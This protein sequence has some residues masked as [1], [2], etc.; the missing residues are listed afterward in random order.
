MHISSAPKPL[1]SA[2]PLLITPKRITLK[3]ACGVPIVALWLAN[4]TGI[5]EDMG[6]IPGLTQWVKDLALL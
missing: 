1:F 5:H 3:N 4:P 6:L 2:N